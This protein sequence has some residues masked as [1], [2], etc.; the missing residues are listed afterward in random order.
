MVSRDFVILD[1]SHQRKYRNHT[2]AKCGDL[3]SIGDAVHTQRTKRSKRICH[4]QCWESMYTP[5]HK[6]FQFIVLAKY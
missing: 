3:F 6:S 2:C 1:Y 4:K 5:D